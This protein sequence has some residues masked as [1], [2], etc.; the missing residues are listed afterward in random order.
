MTGLELEDFYK[1]R[2]L[3]RFPYSDC[4]WIAQ[5]APIKSEGLIPEL[6]WYFANIAGYCS[7]AS[8]LGNRPKGELQKAKK[9]LALSFFETF[10]R[11]AHIERLITPNQTPKLLER[12]EHS[13]QARL[14][15]LELLDSLEVD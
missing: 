9:S 3:G 12:I 13:E 4:Y 8:R 6:D 15:L 7:S 14:A 10:P 11:L 5:N 2:L 1:S